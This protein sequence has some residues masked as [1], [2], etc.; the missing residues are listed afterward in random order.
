MRGSFVYG[1][2]RDSA[3]RVIYA[4]RIED[5]L[6]DPAGLD[7][8]AARMREKLEARG[9]FAAEVVV[10]QG[11]RKETLRLTGSPYAVGRVRAAMFNAA[12]RWTP[13]ELD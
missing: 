10:V 6:L 3:R 8:V 7:Q 12:I 13:I 5:A 4:V 1:T 9:D 11:H 2:V